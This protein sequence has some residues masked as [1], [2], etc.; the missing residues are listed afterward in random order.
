MLSYPWHAGA[1]LYLLHPLLAHQNNLRILR[2]IYD[3]L[4]LTHCYYLYKYQTNIKQGISAISR[5][6]LVRIRTNFPNH[7]EQCMENGCG[8]LRSAIFAS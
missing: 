6:I 1:D 3:A 5:R 4:F 7:L 8:Y 2:N